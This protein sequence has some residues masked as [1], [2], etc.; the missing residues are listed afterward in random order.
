MVVP[1]N[2]NIIEEFKKVEEEHIEAKEDDKEDT[3]EEIVFSNEEIEKFQKVFTESNLSTDAEENEIEDDLLLDLEKEIADANIKKFKRNKNA[4]VTKRT[5]KE[6]PKDYTIIENENTKK[7]KKS[8]VKKFTRKK[9]NMEIE[10]EE[11]K[12]EK[13]TVKKAPVRRNKKAE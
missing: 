5:K 4:V 11:T 13:F 3:E 8:N 7:P 12:T 9:E 6:E 2:T 10:K 1:E